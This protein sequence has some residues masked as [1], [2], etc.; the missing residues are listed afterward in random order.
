MLTQDSVV[1]AE[2]WFFMFLLA[3]VHAS[4][5]FVFD[6]LEWWLYFDHDGVLVEQV[7]EN[8]ELS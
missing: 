8:L 4:D 5:P 3:K 2:G 7:P 1:V 6:S